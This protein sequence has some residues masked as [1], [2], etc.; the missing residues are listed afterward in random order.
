M[1]SRWKLYLFWS[2]TF[3]NSIIDYEKYS[4]HP[5]VSVVRLPFFLSVQFSISK[6]INIAF[7][8]LYFEF[9]ICVLKYI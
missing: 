9:E 2:S 4:Y 6:D 5:N 3:N 7:A 8:D 1:Q